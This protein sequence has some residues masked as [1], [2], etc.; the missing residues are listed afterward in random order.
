MCVECTALLYFYAAFSHFSR[1][2]PALPLVVFF[3]VWYTH[4]NRGSILA[5][6]HCY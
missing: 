2:F 5:C 4:A 3:E 1:F 6:Y